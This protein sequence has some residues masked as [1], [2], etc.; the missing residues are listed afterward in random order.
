MTSQSISPAGTL[1]PAP[2]ATR[3]KA[4]V[5]KLPVNLFAAVMGFSGLSL[6]WRFAHTSL[7]APALIGE[8]I[9][10][11]A[12]VVF[13]LLAVAYLTKLAKHPGAVHAEFHHP[14]AGYFFGTI[15]ISILLLSAVIAP[16]SAV[17]AQVTWTVGVLATFGLGYSAVALLLKGRIDVSEAVPAWIIPCVARSTSP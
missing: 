15:A 12:V 13:V 8:A 2:P 6:A 11:L 9:G 3:G 1:P 16:Y 10:A 7:G 4:S 5:S 17:A 14:V